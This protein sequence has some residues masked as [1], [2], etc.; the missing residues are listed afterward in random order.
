MRREKTVRVPVSDLAFYRNETKRCALPR[1][2]LPAWETW[3]QDCQF[4]TVGDAFRALGMT[5]STFYRLIKR[6]P[7]LT[8][9]LAMRAVFHRLRPY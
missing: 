4:R 7:D 6:E 2:A 1:G 3:V 8:T 5:Q 9:R